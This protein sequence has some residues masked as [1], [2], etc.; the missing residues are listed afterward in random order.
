MCRH[1]YD[2]YDI[3]LPK[4]CYKLNNR[5]SYFLYCHVA[6]LPYTRIIST[7]LDYYSKNCHHADFQPSYLNCVPENS[8]SLTFRRLMSTIVDVP[9]R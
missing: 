6:I 1:N 7:A 2:V 9:H 8:L 4:I 5:C 3:S